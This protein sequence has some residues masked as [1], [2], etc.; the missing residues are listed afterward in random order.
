[1]MG[2]QSADQ[3]HLFY[4]FDQKDRVP[5]DYLLRRIDKQGITPNRAPQRTSSTDSARSSHWPDAAA[6]W[7]G[8]F[9]AGAGRATV[10]TGL[11]ALILN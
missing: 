11:D 6:A 4:Q 5:R 7:C 1:M 8:S 10:V 9:A 3:A 2:R